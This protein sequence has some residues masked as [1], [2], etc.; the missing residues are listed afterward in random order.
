M[1][2]VLSTVI[3]VLAGVIAVLAG[4]IAVLGVLTAVLSTVIG[5]LEGGSL[6]S[7]AGRVNGC[8]RAVNRWSGD[9]Y[10]TACPRACNG[11]VP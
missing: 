1:T 8:F 5:L 3:A 10:K 6:L 2:A 11:S 7:N 4:V 9:V